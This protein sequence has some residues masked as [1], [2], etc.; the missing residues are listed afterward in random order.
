MLRTLLLALLATGAV[1]ALPAS[2]SAATCKLPTDGKGFGP[3]YLLKLHTSHVSCA[4]AKKV[5]KAFHRCATRTSP[6]GRCTS[7]VLGLRCSEK[8]YSGPTQ[9]DAKARCTAGKRRVEFT[10]T[11]FT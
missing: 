1:A 8:R 6:K 3:T 9:F 7:K 4:K 2:A 11:Q 10:Y 5:V